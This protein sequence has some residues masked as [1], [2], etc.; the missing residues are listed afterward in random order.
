MPTL[1]LTEL[2]AVKP[3]ALFI[4][5]R[6]FYGVPRP[7]IIFDIEMFD[8]QCEMGKIPVVQRHGIKMAEALLGIDELVKLYP[9]VRHTDDDEGQ[10]VRRLPSE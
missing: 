4:Y 7:Q 2:A 10:Q 6:S 8:Y 9:C 3:E 1:P 5:Y